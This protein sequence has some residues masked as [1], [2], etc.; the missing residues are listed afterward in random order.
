MTIHL[1]EIMCNFTWSNDQELVRAQLVG[2]HKACN[3]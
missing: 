3:H 2:K 1:D